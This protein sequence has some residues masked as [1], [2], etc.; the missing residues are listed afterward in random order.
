MCGIITTKDVLLNMATIV[1][2]FGPRIYLRCC[3]AIVHR[4]RT[5]FLSCI[6]PR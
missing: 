1:R 4:R 2:A 3:M 5:T 6:Y